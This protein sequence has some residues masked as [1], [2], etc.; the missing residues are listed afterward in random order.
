MAGNKIL[1]DNGTEK[2][3]SLSA[4]E[5]TYC[6]FNDLRVTTAKV[7][8][9]DVSLTMEADGDPATFSM[10]VKCLKANDG[11][12]LK[13]VKYDLGEEVSNAGTNKG[14]ASVLDHYN[15]PN[16]RDTYTSD[17]S[18]ITHADGSLNE[19]STITD[20]G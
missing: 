14:V 6:I 13:L 8:A 1:N 12:M 17:A 20:E 9:E 10:S 11:S 16:Q 15:G 5:A 2:E 3:M 7:S 18:T 4:E 19:G